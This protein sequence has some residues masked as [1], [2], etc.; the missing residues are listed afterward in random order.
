MQIKKTNLFKLFPIKI[1]SF[2]C[3]SS[4]VSTQA[5]QVFEGDTNHIDTSYLESRREL[6]DYVLDT[7]DMLKI[8][9]V[10]IP[11]SNGSYN[12]DA[13]G[14]INLRVDQ[15][16]QSLYV[17]GLTISEL[18]VLLEERFDDIIN[19]PKI[20]IKIRIFKPVRVLVSGEV[21][22]PGVKTF[23]SFKADDDIYDN[24]LLN[25]NMFNNKGERTEGFNSLSFNNQLN[26]SNNQNI[27]SSQLIK[28]KNNLITTVS[29]AINKSGGLTPYSDISKLEIVRD[30]APGK[31]GGKKRTVINFLSYLDEGND[32][33]NVRLFDGDSIFVPSL[34]EKDISLVT[35]AILAGISPRFINVSIAGRIENP[36]KIKLPIL[37][38][39][40]DALNLTGPRK[41]L[42]GKVYLVRYTQDGS[43]L[44][45]NI[46]YSSTAKP[47][48]RRNP[49]LL[50]GDLITVQNSLLGRSSGT[51]KAITEPFIGIYSAQ[52]LIRKFND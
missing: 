26:Q 18:K 2:I 33:V 31:G 41:P 49:Y 43:L 25:N 52:E 29:S 42:S 8:N 23:D 19:S 20:N 45:K 35:R 3:L 32:S 4:F 17:R 39:L 10:G 6:K 37:G 34:Q 24:L 27:L 1:I 9:F 14:E 51:I 44:R 21:R 38:S 30:I 16:I 7:G 46:S 28:R 11:E 48:S 5:Q 13:Q 15:D 22:S 36:G 40:S 47:G 50:E 12:V